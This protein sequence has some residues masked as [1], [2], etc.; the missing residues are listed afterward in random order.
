ML[1]RRLENPLGGKCIRVSCPPPSLRVVRAAWA[2][3]PRALVAGGGGEV[4]VLLAVRAAAVVRGPP[5]AAPAPGGLG[6]GGA[7][8]DARAGLVR[9]GLP[10]ARVGQA[11]AGVRFTLE[12]RNFTDDYLEYDIFFTRVG[13]HLP[14]SIT[15][16]PQ[17]PSVE[18]DPSD[19]P[20]SRREPNLG[21]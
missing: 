18:S 1:P 13:R 6:C 5:G 4:A 15:P 19:I 11:G 12:L 17:V 10:G 7:A 14:N 3:E 9:G 20:A 21:F 8:G 16:T 2:A